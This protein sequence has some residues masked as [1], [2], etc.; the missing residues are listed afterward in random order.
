MREYRRAWKREV[1]THRWW[2][3]RLSG[4][5]YLALSS[6]KAIELA[7]RFNADPHCAYCRVFLKD[8]DKI[9]AD[10]GWL[11]LDHKTPKSRGGSDETDNFAFCCRECNSVKGN[12]TDEEFR[13]FLREY[14]TRLIKSTEQKVYSLSEY[15]KR[16]AEA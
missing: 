2:I 16:S 9:K 7:E 15:A 11:T 6:V 5:S 4:N 3:V 1:F 12:R 10:P 13:K 14:T 8:V